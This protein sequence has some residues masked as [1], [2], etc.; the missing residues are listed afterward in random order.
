[1]QGWCGK[2]SY[3]RKLKL[4]VQTQLPTTMRTNFSRRTINTYIYL[5]I[6]QVMDKNCSWF[7]GQ[8]TRAFLE[9]SL[10]VTLETSRCD[11]DRLDMELPLSEAVQ[12][13]GHGHQWIREQLSHFLL[14][15]Y[16]KSRWHWLAFQNSRSFFLVAWLIVRDWKHSKIP[17]TSE[18]W[19]LED[20]SNY[21]LNPLE[22]FFYYYYS[23]KGQ[24]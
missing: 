23:E 7:A 24:R 5:K 1:M 14:S 9:D 17:I 12:K 16:L 8:H 13:Q 4:R 21:S 18:S 20:L 10:I 19:D 3:E 6:L 15:L 2:L 22:F 11:I